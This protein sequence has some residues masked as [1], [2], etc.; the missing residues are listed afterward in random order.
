MPPEE[1]ESIEYYGVHYST[2]RGILG[3]RYILQAYDDRGA[4]VGQLSSISAQIYASAISY[5]LS[6]GED[7]DPSR[8]G[9]DPRRCGV[10]CGRE[11]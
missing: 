7:I 6:G 2:G 11:G 1:S 4:Y 9:E 3:D 10:L 8:Y 5:L